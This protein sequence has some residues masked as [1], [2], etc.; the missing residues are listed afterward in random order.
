MNFLIVFLGAGLGGALRHGVGMI[1]LRWWGSGFPLATLLVN[2]IGCL[3]M[4]FLV[5]WLALRG[6]ASAGWKLFLGTGVLGG[7]TTFSAFSLEVGLLYERGAIGQ[8]LL[9][10]MLSLL[11]SVG[12]LFAGLLWVRHWN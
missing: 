8:A 5:G 1:V 4:G 12:G 3:A 10:V 2:A 7:F 6:E 11:L 9:Y